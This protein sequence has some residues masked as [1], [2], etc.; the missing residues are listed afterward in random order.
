VSGINLSKES[1]FSEE[2]TS[3]SDTSTASGRTSLAK[4]FT[5]HATE[6]KTARVFL[7]KF[8]EMIA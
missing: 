2:F 5:G 4:A 3:D 8:A 6:K 1:S 7:N